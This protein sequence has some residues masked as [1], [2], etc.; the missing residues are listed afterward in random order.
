MKGILALLVSNANFELELAVVCHGL[1]PGLIPESKEVPGLL[2][3]QKTPKWQHNWQHG[4]LS[5]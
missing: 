4:F 5:Y 2:A 1:S 3:T